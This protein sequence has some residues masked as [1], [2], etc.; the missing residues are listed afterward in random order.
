MCVCV[1]VCVCVVSVTVKRPVLPRCAVDGRCRN[2]LYC[3]YL[4]VQ[5]SQQSKTTTVYVAPKEFFLVCFLVCLSSSATNPT[6][7]LDL[8]V[9]SFFTC[10][11]CVAVSGSGRLSLVLLHWTEL[12]HAHALSPA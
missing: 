8:T 2:P 12:C 5:A 10:R 7:V 4:I 11:T 9:H 1:C 6:S 3:Y